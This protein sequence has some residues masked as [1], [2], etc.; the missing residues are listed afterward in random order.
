MSSFV[1]EMTP[2]V[3]EGQDYYRAF[4]NIII[5]VPGEIYS[6]TVN[7][8]DKEKIRKGECAILFSSPE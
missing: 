5:Q 6:S 7:V 3:Q 4:S 8:L 2:A 1:P